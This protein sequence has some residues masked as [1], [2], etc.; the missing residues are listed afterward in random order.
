MRPLEVW[1]WV[2]I[3][4]LVCLLAGGSSTAWADA[5]SQALYAR[6]LI[7][8]NS[9]RWDE[10][11]R[12][13]DEAVKADPNDAR[14]LYYRGLT[15]ARRGQPEVA[16]PDLER[17][18]KLRPQLG[19]VVLDLG[20][21][22]FEAKQYQQATQW[23]ERARNNVAD[24]FRA[25]FFL[26]LTHYR[27]GDFAKAGAYL[28]EAQKDPELRPMAE[29]YSGLA[30]LRQGREAE[31]RS[32]LERAAQGRP[33]TETARAAERYL[34]GVPEARKPPAPGTA[35][36]ARRWSVYAD[37]RFEY[38][39]NVVLAPSDSELKAAQG[40]TGEG[41]GRSVLGFGGEY[42]LLDSEKS[43]ITASYDFYQSLHFQIHQFDLQGHRVR[44]QGTTILDPV[45]LGLAATYDFYALNYQTFFQQVL[46]TPWV[47]I[48]EGEASSTQLY[49]SYRG[50]DFFREPYD[51]SRD[52]ND[53]AVGIR[54][55]ALLGSKD[56]L[57]SIGYQFD[58]DDPVGDF[59]LIDES[60][61]PPTRTRKPNDFQFK[62]HQ[63]DVGVQFPIAN[64]VTTQLAYLFRFEDYQFP[65]S[66]ADYGFRRHDNEHQ[67]VL[68]FAHDLTEHLQLSLAYLAV[69]NNSNIPDFNYDRQIISVG[70]R[71]RY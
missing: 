39:T 3:G 4:G 26:G 5:R 40:I 60:T 1:R 23:L 10:A 16:I 21:A 67:V 18:A 59:I 71:A 64:V 53:D 9:G 50:R 41:D 22:Y 29:Y 70:V 31:A 25:A 62:G 55:Y 61:T 8:F 27:Q 36:G 6:G 34:A 52:D 11:Y 13:F 69:I 56:R 42:R 49:Y 28:A 24:S 38:D 51:P 46:V 58:Q 7:P 19:H 32:M 15:A 54:Q 48:P 47:T 30:L 44:L 68:A 17:A 14:S 65:N 35:A 57:L 45:Q 43:Q 12:L 20:I 33:E 37:T 66:R 2:A 63:F